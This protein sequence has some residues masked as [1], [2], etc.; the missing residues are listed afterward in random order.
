VCTVCGKRVAVGPEGTRSFCSK[1]P[2]VRHDQM[3]TRN[4]LGDITEKAL[5]S[6][7]VTQDRYK[8]AKEIFGMSPTCNCDKRKEWLNRVSDWWNGEKDD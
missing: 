6:I 5:K 8:A 3:A 7:G 2:I 1:N 4:R